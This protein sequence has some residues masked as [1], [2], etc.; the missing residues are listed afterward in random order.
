MLCSRRTRLP[1]RQRLAVAMAAAAAAMMTTMILQLSV[2]VVGMARWRSLTRSPPVARDY[3]RSRQIA[4]DLALA[5][6][7]GALRPGGPGYILN[8]AAMRLLMGIM[9]VSYYCRPADKNHMEDVFIADC[10]YSI[11]NY[12]FS[13]FIEFCFADCLYSIGDPFHVFLFR[14]MTQ[15][16]TWKITTTRPCRDTDVRH[17]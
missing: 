7:I 12:L 4:A 2:V 11:G 8:R 16:A 10:L 17:A 14:L 13:Y 6:P 15:S 5:R 9:D 3:G 1:R